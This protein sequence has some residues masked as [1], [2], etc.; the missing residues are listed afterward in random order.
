[1]A[2]QQSSGTKTP[3]SWLEYLFTSV[4]TLFAQEMKILARL[5]MCRL[6]LAFTK[7]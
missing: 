4:Y 6:V 3:S 5:Q 7:L 2:V 1:M